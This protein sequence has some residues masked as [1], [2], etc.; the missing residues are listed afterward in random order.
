[1]NAPLE[2]LNDNNLLGNVYPKQMLQKMMFV[3]VTKNDQ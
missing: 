3:A 1:M 2:T